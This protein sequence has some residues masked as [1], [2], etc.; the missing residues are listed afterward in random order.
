L[1]PPR[2]TECQPSWPYGKLSGQASD[3]PVVLVLAHHSGVFRPRAYVPTVDEIAPVVDHLQRRERCPRAQRSLRCSETVNFS[4]AQ[5]GPS[6][7]SGNWARG[8]MQERK[9]L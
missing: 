4:E 2:H 6:I 3:R 8:A 9:P 7:R 5:I 1:G